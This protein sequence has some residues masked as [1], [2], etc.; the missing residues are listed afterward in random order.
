MNPDFLKA[1]MEMQ[2]KIKELKSQGVNV[3]GDNIDEFLKA[4]TNNQFGLKEYRAMQGNTADNMIRSFGYGISANQ[5]D[6]I[7]GLFS[8]SAADESRARQEAYSEY[9]PLHSLTGELLGGLG[10]G[11][12][13]EPALGAVLPE[14]RT[15]AGAALHG[16]TAGA[17]Y[18]GVDAEGRADGASLSDKADA[19]GNGALGGAILGG[20]LGAG[21]AGGSKL[22]SADNAGTNRIIAAIQKDGG[23]DAV[24]ANLANMVK[25]GRGNEVTLADLGPHLRQALDFAANESDKVFVPTTELLQARTGERAARLLADVRANMGAPASLAGGPPNMPPDQ[26]RSGEPDFQLR[27]RQLQANTSAVGNKVYGDLSAKSPE[28]DVSTLPLDK[29]KVSRLWNDARL[30]GNITEQGP[31]DALIAK[32]TAA[33]PAAPADAIRA[34]ATHVAGLQGGAVERPASLND[35]MSLRQ[36]L[37]GQTEKAFR[38]GNGAMGNAMA[39]VKGEVDNALEAGAPGYKAAN[40]AY[41]GANDLERGNDDGHDWWF[42]ADKRELARVVA[43]KAQ[44]P[45]ALDEFRRGIAS[46]L[47]EKLQGT[48]SNRD[49][50]RELMQA[51]TDLDAKLKLIFGDE[52]TFQSFMARVKAERTMGMMAQTIGNSSTSRRV[53]ARG[54]DPASL[55]IDAAIKGP[56]M[57]PGLMSSAG[58]AMLLRR[59]AEQMGPSLLTQGAP[60]IESLITHLTGASPLVGKGAL[61]M[62]TTGLLS[63][64]P[65]LN[66]NLH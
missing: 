49:A 55:G 41:R 8:K 50:A 4:K 36:A 43:E 61:A 12:I 27:Q 26:V 22:L 5:M 34:T 38:A 65:F 9:H 17:V 46:G 64:I 13:M 62:P 23:W 44:Q 42:K 24:R 29:P 57:V 56:G 25:A 2:A 3:T 58:K 30:A 11:K 59:T 52:N 47:V 31:L 51:S 15:A 63:M 16:A 60:N 18:G 35:M 7:I 39:G 66:S 20:T 21:I 19:F 54:I 45:G 37:E 1:V 6:N 32:L 53:A 10:A 28:F 33:N 40:T 48:S 14:A